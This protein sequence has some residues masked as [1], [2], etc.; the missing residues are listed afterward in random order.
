MAFIEWQDDMSVGVPVLDDDHKVLINLLNEYV[1]ALEN[2]EGLFVTDTIFRALGD[3]IDTHFRRE[4]DIMARAGYADLAAHKEV[5]RAMEEQF[6]TLRDRF[7][8]DPSDAAQERLKDFLHTWL[9]NHILK[10]DMAYKPACS[11][12]A[13]EI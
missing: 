7:L 2:D 5:H 4:E 13:A 9:T 11:R 10:T 8:L 12:L 3:Y 6:A 1:D